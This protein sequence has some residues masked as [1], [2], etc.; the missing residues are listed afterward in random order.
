MDELEGTTE[1]GVTETIV[2]QQG[3][4]GWNQCVSKTDLEAHKLIEKQH[5]QDLKTELEKLQEI[6]KILRE[7]QSVLNSLNEI[8]LK[9]YQ[10]YVNS[11]FARTEIQEERRLIELLEEVNAKLSNASSG[12]IEDRNG[13]DEI[14]EVTVL[15]TGDKV[16]NV[17][18]NES[19]LRENK[20]ILEL[21]NEVEKLK[22]TISKLIDTKK[23]MSERELQEELER[24]QRDIQ[25]IKRFLRNLINSTNLQN[26]H[27]ASFLRESEYNQYSDPKFIQLQIVNIQRQINQ[28]M[29]KTRRTDHRLRSSDEPEEETEGVTEGSIEKRSNTKT[30]NLQ[31]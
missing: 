23:P 4:T 26:L 10:A 2:L 6:I 31:C 21:R 16:T 3:P 9:Y 24:Q 27:N 20:D 30:F 18:S 11:S 15:P 13:T 12:A 25:G 29:T 5:L 14:E 8:D 28:L 7:Q 22:S 17:K 19:I 1:G